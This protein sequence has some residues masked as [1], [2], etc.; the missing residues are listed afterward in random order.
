MIRGSDHQA[1]DP[2]PGGKLLH[3]LDQGDADS[4]AALG[5]RYDQ[6]RELSTGWVFVQHGNE[7]ESRDS[8]NRPGP[9]LLG[10]EHDHSRVGSHPADAI[11]NRCGGSGI[12]ELAEECCNGIGISFLGRANR[13]HYAPAVNRSALARQRRSAT[14]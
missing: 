4:S 9:D 12:A 8:A 13:N 2:L 6:R 11:T 3:V 7:M 1:G 5:F 10:D 14:R